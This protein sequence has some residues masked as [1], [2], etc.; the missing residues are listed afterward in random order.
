MLRHLEN[1]VPTAGFVTDLLDRER[2][3][4]SWIDLGEVH[5]IVRRAHGED[6]KIET[7][8]DLRGIVD[9]RNRT[10]RAGRRG[11]RGLGGGTSLCRTATAKSSPG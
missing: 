2:P 6:A 8:R 10:P 7:V 4:M 11:A 3:L 9:V 5:Y 1:A